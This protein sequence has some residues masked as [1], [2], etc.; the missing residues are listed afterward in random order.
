MDQCPLEPIVPGCLLTL[1]GGYFTLQCISFCHSFHFMRSPFLFE[2]TTAANFIVSPFKLLRCLA[3]C[4]LQNIWKYQS[5][6]IRCI[7][8]RKATDLCLSIAPLHYHDC[9]FWIRELSSAARNECE[10]LEEEISQCNNPKAAAPIIPKKRFIWTVTL[11]N[12]IICNDHL[13]DLGRRQQRW[14]GIN[15]GKSWISWVPEV[16]LLYYYSAYFCKV[17][18]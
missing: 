15:K 16:R 12:E 11:L 7:V 17:F 1:P 5:V 4:G 14:I 9:A 18:L 3:I 13:L 6:Q 10:E 8:I 2:W